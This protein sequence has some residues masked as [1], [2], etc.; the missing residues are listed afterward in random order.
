MLV[1][2][3]GSPIWLTIIG[4]AVFQVYG[5]ARGVKSAE[6]WLL[7]TAF[8]ATRI[9]PQTIDATTLALTQWWPALL[10]G[11]IQLAK[12]LQRNDSHRVFVGIAF[13]VIALSIGAN[14]FIVLPKLVQLGGPIVCLMAAVLITGA[15]YNDEFAWFLKVMGAPLLVAMT[16]ASGVL[17]HWQETNVQDPAGILLIEIWAVVAFGY[18]RLVRMPLYRLS[19]LTCFGTATSYL[20]EMAVVALIRESGWNGATSFAAGLGWFVLAVAISSW[21][22]GW[23]DAAGRQLR[24]TLTLEVEA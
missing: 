21:K 23:L 17:I 3:F 10:L 4:A 13:T 24:R 16:V 15:A 9:G 2:Q 12:G 8:V 14:E 11:A 5:M 6:A 1:S 22:A 18:G 20:T 7:L 19:A